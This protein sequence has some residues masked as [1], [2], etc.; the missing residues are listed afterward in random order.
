[1][2]VDLHLHTNASDGV[3]SPDQL[4]C[5]AKEKGLKAIAITDHDTVDGVSIALARGVA[6]GLEVIPGL[7]LSTYWQ[8]EEVHILGLFINHEDA[9]LRR[10]LTTLRK[11]RQ[12]RIKKII[13][14]LAEL[15]FPL[16]QGEHIMTLETPGR[17]HVAQALA[18]EGHVETWQDA[19]ALYLK[20]GKPAY[21]PRYKMSSEEGLMHIKKAGG[22]SVLAHPGTLNN[23]LPLT[24][25]LQKMG[26][27]GLEVLHPEHHQDA[28]E[29]F[30]NYAQ[31][32]G[33][34]MSGGSDCHGPIYNGEDH[35]GTLHVPNLWLEQIKLA[36]A[37]G[38][39]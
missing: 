7:E 38:Y 4:I 15:G 39:R 1:M 29:A 11:A 8:G 9:E 25:Y 33:L 26:L 18:A 19:F 20:K 34:F 23:W 13:N 3:Y 24:Q 16:Q 6:M 10:V 17:M 36:A 28:E 5:R 37:Q 35:L 2:A 31:D 30:Y 22:L 21:I 14:R 32:Q 12:E 27:Q